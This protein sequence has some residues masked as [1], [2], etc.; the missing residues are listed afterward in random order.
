MDE[1]REV[2]ME[3]KRLRDDADHQK[4]LAGELRKENTL[5]KS[6]N[7]YLVNKLKEASHVYGE[8]GKR[9]LYFINNQVNPV[10][11]RLNTLESGAKK[12]RSEDKTIEESIVTLNKTFKQESEKLSNK[13]S[14]LSGEL[15]SAEESLG[16]AIKGSVSKPQKGDAAMEEKLSLLSA[17]SNEKLDALKTSV[18]R[19]TSARMTVFEK[20]LE[21]KMDVLRERNLLL[22]KDIEA[23][24]KLESDVGGLDGRV[25]EVI[26]HL[27]QARM[28]VENLGQQ[29]KR[30][31]SGIKRESE[32]KMRA[33]SEEVDRKLVSF[34][35]ELR[36]VDEKNLGETRL[37]AEKNQEAVD[38]RLD[39]FRAGMSAFEKTMDRKLQGAKSEL[40]RESASFMRDSEERL[41]M[42]DRETGESRKRDAAFEREITKVREEFL[43][44]INSVR[45]DAG[46]LSK[47]VGDLKAMEPEIKNLA[48]GLRR[49]EEFSAALEA[50]MNAVSQETKDKSEKDDMRLKKQ[51]DVLQFEIKS[52]METAQSRMSEENIR[53]FSAARHSLR[54]DIH[55]LREE[56]AALKAETKGLLGL[57][58]I[59]NGLQ[60]NVMGMEN[61]I[62]GFEHTLEQVSASTASQVEKE[63]LKVGKDMAGIAARLKSDLKDIVST[64][65]A[66][67]SKQS[68]DLNA[69]FEN[70]MAAVGDVGKEMAEMKKHS[71]GNYHFSKSTRLQLEGL[72]KK[73]NKVLK[74]MAGMEKKYKLEMDRLLKE[75]EG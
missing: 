19:R 68:A 24:L 59:V 12:L 66:T 56:N 32:D 21:K 39:T 6:R 62:N 20:A 48:D 3:L 47:D 1:L 28:D 27:S 55:T 26:S 42:L 29:L 53:A 65:K 58:E 43:S 17:D 7:E 57:A 8:A 11:E 44:E 51:M 22:G 23:L 50:K 45:S 64:E 73:L 72:N 60:R 67:F 33:L 5:L 70:L 61:E 4:T 40:K 15:S 13:I 41:K 14:S 38:K 75:I 46:L 63:A 71:A 49:G 31:M 34:S 35:S 10:V 16:S 54:K 25:Q 30:G 74:D 36:Q 9:L 37:E 18:A 52:S 69:R 2:G